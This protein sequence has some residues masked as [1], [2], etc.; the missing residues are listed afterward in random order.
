MWPARSITRAPAG[1]VADA[2]GRHAGDA[3][4]L[5][6]DCPAL[7]GGAPV[8]STT[9]TFVSAMTGSDTVTYSLDGRASVGGRLAERQPAR[10]EENGN[11]SGVQRDRGSSVHLEDHAHACLD[12]L[13]DVAVQH[14]LARVGDVEQHVGDEPGRHQHRVLPDGLSFGTPLMDNTRNR[15]P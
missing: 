4:V 12:V 14:P 6:D 9:R 1:I 15:W 11:G 5:D 3:A 7:D 8:P 2:A 13:G 10:G